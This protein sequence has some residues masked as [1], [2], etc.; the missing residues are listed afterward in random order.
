MG[1][2]T[3]YLT[4]HEFR[5][6]VKS[7]DFYQIFQHHNYSNLLQM[8]KVRKIQILP[9]SFFGP[10]FPIVGISITKEPDHYNFLDQ[11]LRDT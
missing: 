10:N 6:I 5:N 11:G 9:K 2:L 7:L 4:P 3:S 8:D 1:S